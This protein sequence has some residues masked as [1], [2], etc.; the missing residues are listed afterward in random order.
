VELAGQIRELATKTLRSEY[1]QIDPKDAKVLLF[2]GGKVPL[3][4][5]GDKLSHKASRT[6]HDLG[7][8]TH[9]GSIVASVDGDGLVA[10]DHDGNVTRYQAGTVLW[11]ADVQAPPIAKAVAAATGV[12]PDRAGRIGVTKNL[13]IPGYPEISVVGDMM[14][15]NKLPGLAEVAM[16]SGHYAARRIRR[17]S[18]GKPVAKP[19]VYHDLGSAAYIARGRAVLC[20]GPVHLSGF[21]GWIGWLF[22]HIAFL[23]GY[24]NRVGAV[25]TWWVAVTRDVRR[26]RAYTT[27]QVGYVKDI[28]AVDEAA[29]PT[30]A[31]PP[32]QR[33]AAESPSTARPGG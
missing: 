25:L 31:Q 11:T 3:A 9:M 33:R 15:L 27:R 8:E 24:R 13:T 28:Y 10:R 7:V 17:E 26:E 20:A 4:M 1:R 18:Q 16:Q 5:F 22:V 21:L 6:L 2:D 19:F 14:R 32:Q 30:A 23:T 29:A 12:Q